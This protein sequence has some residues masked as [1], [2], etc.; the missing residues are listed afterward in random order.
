[1]KFNIVILIVMLL[2][3]SKIDV[4]H[5]H[6]D[7]MLQKG[8]CQRRLVPGVVFM[9]A[10]AVAATELIKLV[11]TNKGKGI[12]RSFYSL[13]VTFVSSHYDFSYQHLY[14]FVKN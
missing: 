13:F 9:G 4:V 6:A 5:A 7:D 2:L 1:M 12:S 3:A 8:N 10:P 14:R 11:I